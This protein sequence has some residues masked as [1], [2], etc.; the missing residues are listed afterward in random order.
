VTLRLAKML[1]PCFR[2]DLFDM[3]FGT[4]SLEVKDNCQLIKEEFRRTKEHQ[5]KLDALK[6]TPVNDDPDVVAI[7]KPVNQPQDGQSLLSCLAT[8]NAEKPTA[9]VEDEV[10]DYLLANLRFTDAQIKC[11]ETPLKWWKVHTFIF[12]VLKLQPNSPLIC[13][14]LQHQTGK[15]RTISNPGRDGP[16]LPWD[17]S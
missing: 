11:K 14:H 8:R 10:K 3:V 4:E 17:T 13:F 15:P 12:S 6:S 7:E 2:L 1:H 16:C 9:Q 5:K